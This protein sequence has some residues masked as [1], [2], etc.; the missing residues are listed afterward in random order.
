MAQDLDNFP[1]YDAVIK[2]DSYKLSDVWRDFMPAFL[3]TLQGY[4]SSRGIFFPQVT[5]SERDGIQSPQEGQV[6]YN[7]TL[8]KAQIWQ[9]GA[10]VT[11]T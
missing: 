3:Q 11:F 2:A 5:T 10:W 8:L 4:V 6:I 9:N 1:I 7:T